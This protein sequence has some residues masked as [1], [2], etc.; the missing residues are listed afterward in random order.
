MDENTSSG[1]SRYEAHKG[2]FHRL[3]DAGAAPFGVPYEM[4]LVNEVVASFDGLLTAGGRFAFPAAWYATQTSGAPQTARPEVEIALV[5]G[6]LGQDKPVLG[7]CAGM[8]ALACIHGAKLNA[9]VSG[10]DAGGPHEVTTLARTQLCA[11]A[12]GRLSVNS[13]HREALATL[14][15]A[16]IA[17]AVADDGVIEAIE[18]PGCRFAMGLQWHQE[19]HGLDHPGQ[20]I[21]GGFVEAAIPR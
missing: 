21:F 17:S 4:S 7:M 20:A 1:G 19:L 13:Y 5:R 3:I 11:L 2:Y 15:G 8:Q 16:V 9:N 14:S 10:H 18:I 12:G 6:F